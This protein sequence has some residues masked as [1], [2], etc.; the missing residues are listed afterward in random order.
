MGFGLIVFGP[1]ENEADST[2]GI[3]NIDAREPVILDFQ[4][5][6]FLH[7]R[8]GRNSQATSNPFLLLLRLGFD[9][10]PFFFFI[11]TTR[12]TVNFGT[13]TKP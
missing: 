7:R 6:A 10:V 12:P 4:P 2:D 11:S 8:R 1:Q 13:Q 9:L 5:G 3:V